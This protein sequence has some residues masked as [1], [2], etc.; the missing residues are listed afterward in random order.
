[1]QMRKLSTLK[2]VQR[3]NALKSQQA[4]KQRALAHK[5]LEQAK[6]QINALQ[7]FKIEYAGKLNTIAQQGLSGQQLGQFSNF[8]DTLATQCDKAN[9]DLSGLESHC[10]QADANWRTAHTELE[11][12][13]KLI[14]KETLRLKYTQNRIEAKRED[15]EAVA[16]FV[17]NR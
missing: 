14:E 8:M 2:I 9:G 15:E 16:F 17:R 1:M 6:S 4:L 7:N 10:T 12:Y 5:N 13:N 11:K 3:L